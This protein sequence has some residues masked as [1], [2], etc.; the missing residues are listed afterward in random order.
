MKESEKLQNIANHARYL[1]TTTPINSGMGHP[2]G[3]TSN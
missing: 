2:R 1:I 3:S